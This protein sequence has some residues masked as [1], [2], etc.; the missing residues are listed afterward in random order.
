MVARDAM[1][2]AKAAAASMVPVDAVTE[3]SEEE[4]MKDLK[5][6][7]TAAAEKIASGLNSLTQNL[8]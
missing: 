1:T 7:P 2:V 3:V 8:S 5:E 4:E 6:V